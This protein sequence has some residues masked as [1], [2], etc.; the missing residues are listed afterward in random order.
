MVVY[1]QRQSAVW[2][3]C[4]GREHAGTESKALPVEGREVKGRATA[5]DADAVL[6]QPCD[7]LGAVGAAEFF[8]QPDGVRE[9]AHA[10]RF[11]RQ[12][13]TIE[14]SPPLQKGVVTF[15]YLLT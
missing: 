10:G 8:A 4:G 1:G 12:A 14:L 6:P 13:R 11:G 7:D 2:R 5:G 15:G 3:R 9:P